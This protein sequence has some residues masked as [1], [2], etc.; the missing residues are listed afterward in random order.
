MVV[1]NVVVLQQLVERDGDVTEARRAQE[2][3][4]RR[5]RGRK[6]QFRLVLLNP[7]CTPASKSQ[8]CLRCV[9][10]RVILQF[11]DAI[12]KSVMQNSY[13]WHLSALIRAACTRG[14]RLVL[15][16]L[17]CAR[18]FPRTLWLFAVRTKRPSSPASMTS[19]KP[20]SN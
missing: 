2:A 17:A 9:S 19:S 13:V 7:A 8:K 3:M 10:H 5:K 11:Y 18:F 20:G 15:P 4:R 12:D 1:E 14:Q 16:S 6:L